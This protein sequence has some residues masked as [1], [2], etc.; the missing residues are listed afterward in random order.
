V[1]LFDIATVS[2]PLPSH[3]PGEPWGIDRNRLSRE[4]GQSG[5]AVPDTIRKPTLSISCFSPAD[6]GGQNDRGAYIAFVLIA[7]VT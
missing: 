4:P 7:S 1:A 3:C 5:C 2:D 6:F